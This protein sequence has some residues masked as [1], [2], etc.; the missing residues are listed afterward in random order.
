MSE[1]LPGTQMGLWFIKG[2]S[3]PGEDWMRSMEFVFTGFGV[4]SGNVSPLVFCVTEA[5]ERG[6]ACR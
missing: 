4:F 2:F 3:S 1:H 5:Q 6:L